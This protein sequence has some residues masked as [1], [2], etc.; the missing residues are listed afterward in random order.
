MTVRTN[1]NVLLVMIRDKVQWSVD[2]ETG[3][4]VCI[5]GDRDLKVLRIATYSGDCDTDANANANDCAKRINFGVFEDSKS[6]INYGF[7]CVVVNTVNN[8]GI[9]D[10]YLLNAEVQ[11]LS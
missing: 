11:V 9:V 3:S 7:I 5:S 1:E 10:E 6:R 2:E 4:I 8:D